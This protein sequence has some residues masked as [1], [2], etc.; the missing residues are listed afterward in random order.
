[1]HIRTAVLSYLRVRSYSSNC[2]F[3]REA[4]HVGVLMF[5]CLL[6][7]GIQG[8]PAS[9]EM[10]LG[11]YRWVDRCVARGN[12]RVL[13]VTVTYSNCSRLTSPPTGSPGCA[14][15]S[16]QTLLCSSTAT[17]SLHTVND[18]AARGRYPLPCTV[19]SALNT[20][21]NI[22]VCAL[23]PLTAQQEE[24]VGREQRR[25]ADGAVREVKVL[26]EELNRLKD[27]HTVSFSAAWRLGAVLFPVARSRATQ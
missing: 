8:R 19:C 27:A 2:S 4:Q 20:I 12:F 13:R 11:G 16:R 3:E 5:L 18:Q 21:L 10:S 14:S 22:D 6:N 25:R 23:P 7:P 24:G 26:R 15:C 17:S 9:S 1:M